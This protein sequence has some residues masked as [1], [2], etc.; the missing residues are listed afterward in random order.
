[1]KKWKKLYSRGIIEDVILMV[2]KGLEG[3]FDGK[4]CV[5]GFSPNLSGFSNTVM[6]G[7]K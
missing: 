7:V 4:T 3:I 2:V 5:L 1:M 6:M